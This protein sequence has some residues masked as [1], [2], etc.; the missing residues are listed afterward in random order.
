MK[1]IFI[2]FFF[3]TFDV[4]DSKGALRQIIYIYIPLAMSCR[5]DRTIFEFFVYDFFFFLNAKRTSFD[6]NDSHRL[7]HFLSFFFKIVFV[8]FPKDSWAL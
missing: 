3:F 4:L 7:T 6:I 1:K 8:N 5:H 2:I